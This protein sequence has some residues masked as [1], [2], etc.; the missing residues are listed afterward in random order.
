M[1]TSG[2]QATAQSIRKASTTSECDGS[3]SGWTCE[4]C[5]KLFRREK[6]KLLEF[7]Y[8]EKHYRIKCLKYKPAE[9][10][11]MRKPG[12]MWFCM[13]CK[14]K[15]EKIILNEKSIENRCEIYF[16]TLN[17]RIEEIEE[18]KLHT[19]CDAHEVKEIIRKEIDTDKGR[20]PQETQSDNAKESGGVLRETINEIQDRKARESSFLI[21]NAPEPDTNLKV[22]RGSKDKELV[23][24]LCDVNID[25]I[26]INEVIRLG[27]KHRMENLDQ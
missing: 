20:G 12:C 5:G 8:C 10:E 7:E 27:K 11:A 15:I 1:A 14:P 13:P 3:A 25:Q 2:G 23:L 19:K 21:F 24:G 17:A 9:Y 22:V 16:S 4:E 6:D 18:K 26:D